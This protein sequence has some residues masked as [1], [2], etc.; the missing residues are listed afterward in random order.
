MNYSGSCAADCARFARFLCLSASLAAA[1]CSSDKVA[2]LFFS[3]SVF[4]YRLSSCDM[5]G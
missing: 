5:L 2:R 4:L 3:F 1:L